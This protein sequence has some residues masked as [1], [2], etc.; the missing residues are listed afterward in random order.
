ML[1]R[2]LN[3]WALN[4]VLSETPLPLLNISQVL[5]TF[6]STCKVKFELVQDIYCDINAGVMEQFPTILQGRQ[7][8]V[9]KTSRIIG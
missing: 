3:S 4:E 2:S 7:S 9:V 1:E 8:G 6:P 5:S